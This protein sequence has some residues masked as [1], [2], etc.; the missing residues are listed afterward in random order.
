[1]SQA[2]GWAAWAVTGG[3]LA[4]GV[5]GGCTTV[6]TGED[7]LAPVPGAPAPPVA[8][9]P[10]PT[11]TG[12]RRINRATSFTGR[13]AMTTTGKPLSRRRALQLSGAAALAAG[14]PLP[15]I[16]QSAT[17]VP[18]NRTLIIGGFA[19]APTWTNYQ[20]A[21]YYAAGVDLRNGLMYASEPLFW[22]NL[23][24]DELIPW[25]AESYSY[26]DDFRQ[27][28]MDLAFPAEPFARTR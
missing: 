10:G 18:R 24:K 21:N 11:I 17:E 26:S 9:A 5:L 19:E 6:K 22:Y 28:M 25:L 23:F 12:D 27:L 13:F 7:R 3:A 15:A 8:A 14:A 20:N 2:R 16:A 1:M 4:L